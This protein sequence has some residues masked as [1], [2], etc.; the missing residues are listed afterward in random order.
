MI[1]P[2]TEHSVQTANHIPV[3]PGEDPLGFFETWPGGRSLQS[4]MLARNLT[5]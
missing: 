1:A 4:P 3:I 5:L 2:E